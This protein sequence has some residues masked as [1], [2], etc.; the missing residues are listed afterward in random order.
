MPSGGHKMG[1]KA[2]RMTVGLETNGRLTQLG[3]GDCTAGWAMALRGMGG[4]P[5]IPPLKLLVAFGGPRALAGVG[6]SVL[7]LVQT[8]ALCIPDTLDRHVYFPL[9]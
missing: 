3:S 4:I 2:V 7:Q 9:Q 8:P 5:D 1:H 6:H